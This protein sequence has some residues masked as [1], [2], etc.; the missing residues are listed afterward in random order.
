MKPRLPVGVGRLGVSTPLWKSLRR[1][2][3]G[4]KELC[5]LGD[6]VLEGLVEGAMVGFLRVRAMSCLEGRARGALEY[7]TLCCKRM[8]SHGVF[9]ETEIAVIFGF[10]KEPYCSREE[11]C[12]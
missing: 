1:A 11:L 2:G 8:S 10:R 4:W 9:G 12:F 5:C 3:L 6:H 7:W